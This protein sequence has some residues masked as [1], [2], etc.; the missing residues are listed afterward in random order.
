MSGLQT[1]RSR[2]G[3]LKTRRALTRWQ[4]AIARSLVLVVIGLFALL[5]IDYVLRLEVVPRLFAIMVIVGTVAWW[6][7][8]RILP[9]IS[10]QESVIDIALQL[11]R[12]HG[13]DSDLVAAL[14]FDAAAERGVAADS[15]AA[16]CEPT[17]ASCG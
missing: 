16:T 14:Q 17:G 10:K 13:V 6:A 11:E 15:F 9:D 7:V 3:R 1:F 12:T 5:L 4:T 2:L 8:R